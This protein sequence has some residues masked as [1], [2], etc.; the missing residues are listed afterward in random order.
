MY[1]CLFRM[2]EFLIKLE[3]HHNN[4]HSDEQQNPGHS[5]SIPHLK[6]LE[7]G[8]VQIQRTEKG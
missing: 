4:Q 7:C 2:T 5:G 8:V 3:Q 6:V 1:D